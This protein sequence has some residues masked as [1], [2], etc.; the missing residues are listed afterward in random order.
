MPEDPHTLPSGSEPVGTLV[1]GGIG[2][3]GNPVYQACV[4]AFYY[5]SESQVD[6]TTVVSL[7]TG[8]FSGAQHPS[9]LWTWLDWVL[10]ELLRSPGEQQTEI[11]YRHFKQ[12][13]FYRLD[14][15]LT[16]D[17]PLDDVGNIAQLRAIGERFAALIDWN[18]ILAG[19][20]TTFRVGVHKT[21]WDEYKQP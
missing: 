3:T 11:I 21:Q 14:T 2:V 6:T 20:D 9:W 17:I 10:H 4:E 13:R 5:T 1:D 7:G 18:A 12:M 16:E 15:A 19:T 8:R